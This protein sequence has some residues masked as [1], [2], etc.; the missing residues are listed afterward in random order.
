MVQIRKN[1]N[2]I[3]N[4]KYDFTNL[5][6]KFFN[7]FAIHKAIG[8]QASVTKKILTGVFG[9]FSQTLTQLVAQLQEDKDH[10]ND[11]NNTH[12][13]NNNYMSGQLRQKFR[14]HST[15]SPHITDHNDNNEP[16]D[17]YVD[18]NYKHYNTAIRR[19]EKRLQLRNME[20]SPKK[21]KPPLPERMYKQ[22]P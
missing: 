1:G 18:T 20:S 14:R 12:Y 10:Y 4:V 17:V 16:I 9:I 6:I 2:N 8:K 21:Q 5:I 15:D 22:E 3:R 13:G 11:D 7:A 19:T